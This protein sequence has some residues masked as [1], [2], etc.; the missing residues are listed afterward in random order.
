MCIYSFFFTHFQE[1]V[2][3]PASQDMQVNLSKKKK[4]KIIQEQITE[5]KLESCN[6]TSCS[7]CLEKFN[8]K[9]II[10]EIKCKHVFHKKC[11]IRW[12]KKN[13]SC[14]ICRFCLI[15]DT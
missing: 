3:D 13:P 10:V 11:F 14:P 8:N 2:Q 7:I 5:I 15:A 4:Y 12:T 6:Q 9:Y 1:Q